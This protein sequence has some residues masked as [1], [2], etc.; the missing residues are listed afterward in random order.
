MRALPDWTQLVA[1]ETTKVLVNF[2]SMLMPPYR[3]G[4]VSHGMVRNTLERH[5]APPAANVATRF[6]NTASQGDLLP[7]HTLLVETGTSLRFEVYAKMSLP[8]TWIARATAVIRLY[9]CGTYA[10]VQD[11]QSAGRRVIWVEFPK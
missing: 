3:G 9:P 5:L 11:G 8:R 7:C 2:V 6:L 10:V 1:D 4:A